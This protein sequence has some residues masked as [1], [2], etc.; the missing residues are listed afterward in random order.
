MEIKWQEPSFV[1]PYATVSKLPDI[2]AG[3]GKGQCQKYVALMKQ[4]V[5]FCDGIIQ[6]T[7]KTT[8][9]DIGRF[10]QFLK[11]MD[12]RKFKS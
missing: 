8:L 7:Q 3:L 10:I 6:P 4:E 5:E 12:E 1:P 9:V 2:L 11:Y